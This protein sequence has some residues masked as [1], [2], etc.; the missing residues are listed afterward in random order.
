MISLADTVDS[1][2]H[3][4]MKATAA[5]DDNIKTQLQDAVEMKGAFEA[6]DTALNKTIC[7]CFKPTALAALIGNLDETSDEE[8]SNVDE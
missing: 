3:D 8:E 4:I 5:R 6:D 7:T 2:L 1:R